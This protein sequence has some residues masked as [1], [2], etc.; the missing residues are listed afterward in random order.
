MEEVN[1]LDAAIQA[2]N[3]LVRKQALQRLCSL[4]R[5]GGVLTAPIGMKAL[6]LQALTDTDAKVRRWAFNGLAQLGEHRDVPLMLTPWRDNRP[7]EEV[8]EAGLT[9]LAHLLSKEEMLVILRKTEVDLDPGIVMALGQQTDAFAHELSQLRLDIAVASVAELRSA[10]LLVGL[11]KAPDTLFS[12]RFPVSDVIGDLNTHD[13]VVVAQYSFWATV[14]HPEL[15]LADVRVRPSEFSRLP[16]NVQGWAYRTLTKDGAKAFDHYDAIVEGSMSSHVE[17]REG[18][19]TGIRDIYYDSL[20]TT[21]SDWFMEENDPIVLDRLLEHM[22]AHGGRSSFYREEVLRSYR[23]AATRSVLRSRLEAANRDPGISLEM[24]RIALQT[25]DPDLFASVVGPT[26][27]NTQHFNATVNAGGISNSGT[28]NTGH[29]QIISAS[30]AQARALPI[31]AELRQDLGG[32]G[33]GKDVAEVGK[34]TNEAIEKPTKGTVARVVSSLK[35]L[36]EGSEAIAGIGSIAS[37]AYDRLS[38]LLD[39]LPDVI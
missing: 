12:G 34:A 22:A 21:V 9:A 30:E 32:V 38:P 14:E 4:Y 16:P 39:H 2:D 20:D 35:S 18:V 27:T 3:A 11:C 13:D 17:V 28:G 19:A 5:A 31:L 8:F 1:F 36:K 24:R 29:V 15:G 37:K 26:M 23:Q 10:T 33:D 7:H 25:G 6:V